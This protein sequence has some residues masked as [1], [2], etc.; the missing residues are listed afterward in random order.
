[1]RRENTVPAGGWAV[2]RLFDGTI[3]LSPG[4]YRAVFRTDPRQDYGDWVRN[5]PFDPA[6]WGVSLF[7]AMPEAVQPVDPWEDQEPFIRID[8]VGDNERHI[9]RFRV[10]APTRI[11]VYA[12]GEM[13][14]DDRYDYATI[15]AG[16]SE[17]VVWEMTQARSLPAGGR[18]NRRE[19]AFLDLPP[20]LYTVTY[21]TDD[22]HSYAGWTHGEPD[23]PERWGVTLFHIDKDTDPFAI[24][25]L[26]VDREAFIEVPDAEGDST[27]ALA[28]PA[29]PVDRGQ[30]PGGGA[31]EAPLVD[32]TGLGN[33]ERVSAPFTFDGEG[34]LRIRAVGEVSLSG[35][36][37]YGWIENAETGETV[38]EMTWQNTIPAGGDDRNRMFVGTLSLAPG[39]Y[40]VYFTTDFSHA[41]GDFEDSAPNDPE[42]WG[43]RVFASRTPEEME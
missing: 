6:G 38:W 5:P 27:F 22:S 7:T 28:A 11:A 41:Y 16:P 32:L 14:D 1:M 29:Q 42:A 9:A 20:G 3:S 35:Q 12:L 40:T 2:N 30:F 39:A 33:R 15:T 36:Y 25:V 37:D 17:R 18:N 31:P 24:E 13:G 19:L 23:Y 43:I 26:T 10:R 4:L 21:Q 8:R 34:F